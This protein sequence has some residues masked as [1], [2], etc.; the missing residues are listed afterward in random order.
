[1][2]RKRPQAAD[3]AA[4]TGPGAQPNPNAGS[5]AGLTT[6][7][8]PPPPATDQSSTALFAELD[9]G[10]GA[11]RATVTLEPADAAAQDDQFYS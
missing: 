3:T 4:H 7:E 8:P 11:H 5:A 1:M 9:L 6:E 2:A 10:T